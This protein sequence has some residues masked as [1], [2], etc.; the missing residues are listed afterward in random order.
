M[1]ISIKKI[2]KELKPC[3][4][5]KR[6]FKIKCKSVFFLRGIIGITF[7]IFESEIHMNCI[8]HVVFSG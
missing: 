7:S 5:D 2:K 3:Y 6:I 8:L 1:V 4:T